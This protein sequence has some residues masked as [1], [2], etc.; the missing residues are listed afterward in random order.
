MPIYRR[1]PKRGFTNARFRTEYTVIN[2]EKLEA[3][4]NGTE[5]TLETVLQAGLVSQNTALLKVLGNGELTKSL[6]VRAQKFS[7]SAADK[8]TSAGGTV[9]LLDARGREATAAAQED[10]AK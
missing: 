6:T 5:V 9:V 8:I 10:Q 4:D 2:V 1:V 7:K 3:F